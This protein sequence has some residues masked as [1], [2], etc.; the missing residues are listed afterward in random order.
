ME[1]KK[2]KRPT[3]A[4]L[5]CL[6]IAAICWVFITFSKDYK[7]TMDYHIQCI[8][9]PQ[10]KRSVTVSDTILSLTFNQKGLRYLMKP[11]SN[12]NK[13]IYISVSDLIKPKN[14]VS[15]YTFT[16]REMRDYLVQ[17]N[18]GSELVSVDAPEVVT[19]YLQ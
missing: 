4:F 14:R 5:V 10:G 18:F 13:V 8:N 3:F 7:V 9:L 11:Y 6:L 12:K 17:Y 1:K 15:V 19:F 2:L 16:N